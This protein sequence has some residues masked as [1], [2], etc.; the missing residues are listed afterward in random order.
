[1]REMRY[2]ALD[3]GQR[4]TGVAYAESGLGVPFPLE[5]ITHTSLEE[6]YTKLKPLLEERSI[7]EIIIGLPLLPSGDEGS[8][9]E[10]VRSFSSL[11]GDFPHEFLDERYTTSREKISDGDARSACEILTVKL[12]L[13]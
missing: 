11:L 10:F 2:I 5:T 9:A 12:D 8:Q 1:M 13:E 7:D 3:I 6:L 4:R